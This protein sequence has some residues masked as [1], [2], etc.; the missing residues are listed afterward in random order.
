M[1]LRCVR[2]RSGGGLGVCRGALEI[3]MQLKVLE[4]ELGTVGGAVGR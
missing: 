4:S 3:D 1:G 2:D